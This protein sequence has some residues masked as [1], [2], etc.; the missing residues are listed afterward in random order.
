MAPCPKM[1]LLMRSLLL[2][3]R[4]ERRQEEGAWETRWDGWEAL[5]LQAC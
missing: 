2:R 5:G 4:G 1:M 3:L